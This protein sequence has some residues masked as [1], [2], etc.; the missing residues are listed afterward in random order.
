M[1]TK[2]NFSE[3]EALQLIEQTILNTRQR[4]K[5]DGFSL[6][7]WGWIV[8]VGNIVSYFAITQAMPIL[9]IYW[10]VVCPAGGIVSGIYGAKKGKSENSTTYTANVMKFIWMGCGIGAILLWFGAAKMGWQYIN[11]AMFVAFAIPVFI[12]GGIMKFKAGIIG[13]L[14]L[15]VFGIISFFIADY[16]WAYLVAS[17][18]WAIGYLV[19]G[20][21]LKKG[22]K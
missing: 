5:D 2:K 22:N 18:G 15:F 7:M 8:I 19:P 16:S 14:I 17:L 12:T 11:S 3:Q 4:F 13:G 20:Y 6:I 1:E 10:A 21:L 9:H